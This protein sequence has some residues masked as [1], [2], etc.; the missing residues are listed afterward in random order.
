M[1]LR[2]LILTQDD[3]RY[4]PVT[5]PEWRDAEGKPVTVLVRT[6]TSAERDQFEEESLVKKGKTR[7]LSLKH[8]RARLVVLTAC[9]PD[10]SPLF[11]PTDTLVLSGK[12]SAA[13]DKLFEV[14]QRLSGLKGE[15]VEALAKNSAS[16][17]S[18]DS[19]SS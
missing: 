5:I 1:L 15:D 2:D 3:L 4:E 13:L 10:K 6:L 17:Q 18:D 11:Q 8:I 12:N 7:E 14:A 19:G 9:N 16:V